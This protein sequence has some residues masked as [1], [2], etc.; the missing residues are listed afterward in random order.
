[1]QIIIKFKVLLLLYS[2]LLLSNN[3]IFC[4]EGNGFTFVFYN[5]ENLFDTEDDPLVRDEEFLP[6][7]DKAWHLDKY[8]TKI[9]H[10]ARV[11][12][13]IGEWDLPEVVGLCEVENKGVLYDLVD[14]RLLEN[15]GYKIIHK[16]SPDERGIDVALLYMNNRF[17]PI[18]SQWIPICFP[19]DSSLRTRDILYVQGVIDSKDT[20]NIFINHWPSRWG[21]V[22]ASMPKRLYV[23]SVLRSVIDSIQYNNEHRNIL[24]AGDFNDTPADSSLKSVLGAGYSEEDDALHLVNLMMP[25]HESGKSGTLKYKE[26]W[27]IYDQ[28][29]ISPSMFKLSYSGLKLNGPFIYDAPFLLQEDERYLG[30]KPY[31]TYSG[32]RYLGGFSD[33][34]PVYISFEF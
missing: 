3:S 32:P 20:L 27:E 21:G 30:I 16:D 31:R 2:M 5:V 18:E 29:I 4:Q 12:T 19:F 34:L 22:V 24:I 17:V 23:A 10:I 8:Y 33:H 28:I 15:Y 6:D 25:M 9:D 14:H 26:H 11:L 1:M 13:G 7:G